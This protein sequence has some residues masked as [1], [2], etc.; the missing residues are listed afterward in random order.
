MNPFTIL[1]PP[2]GQALTWLYDIW[3]AA[4]L[5]AYMAQFGILFNVVLAVFNMLPVPPLDGG[6]VLSGVLSPTASTAVDRIEPFGF[7]IVILLL[8]TGVLWK[9]IGP[10]VMFVAGI[11]FAIAV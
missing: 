1:A 11:F 7:M 10:I 9:I 6:R 3:P 2:L 8:V 4:Q 5:L